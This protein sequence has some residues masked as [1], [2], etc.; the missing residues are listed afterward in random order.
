MNCSICLED[1]DDK[2]INPRYC[3][4]KMYFH[5]KCLDQCEEFNIFCPVCRKK[6]KTILF[7]NDFHDILHNF[8]RPLEIFIRNPNFLTFTL[9]LLYTISVTIFVFIPALIY[10]FYP[11]ILKYILDIIIIILCIFGIFLFIK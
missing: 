5:E 9:V 7:R 8:E 10:I 6:H 11:N 4:C 3:A 2:F 1:N